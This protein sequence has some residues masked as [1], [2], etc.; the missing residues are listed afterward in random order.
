VTP[1]TCKAG[2][3][4]W[5]KAS[6]FPFPKGDT[7]NLGRHFLWTRDYEG[8]NDIS[9]FIKEHSGD[10]NSETFPEH[11]NYWFKVSPDAFCEA[12]KR[13]A[14]MFTYR[15]FDIS[16]IKLAMQAIDSEHKNKFYDEGVRIRQVG[17][18]E[19]NPKH[20]YSYLECGT[21][22]SLKVEVES[23][24]LNIR[25]EIAK[26]FEDGYVANRMKLVIVGKEPLDILKG[27]AIDLFATIPNKPRQPNHWET[28]APLGPDFLLTQCFV[29]PR[30]DWTWI[31]LEFPFLNKSSLPEPQAGRYICHLLDHQGPGS[32]CSTLDSEYWVEHVYS[33]VDVEI[34]KCRVFLT[35]EGFKHYQEVTKSVW[36]YLGLL[37]N[38]QPQEEIFKE[39]AAQ[40]DIA[41]KYQHKVPA[42]DFARRTSAA[43][44]KQLPRKHILN[45]SRKDS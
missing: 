36:Q 38:L 44:Q 31:D 7:T 41:F 43:M 22:N 37:T 40:T 23:R 12:L 1:I 13:F 39:I 14:Q 9:K 24:G 4:L 27:W 6:P 3:L 19:S 35:D 5:S 45:H 10:R 30:Q 17:K 8:G 16:S 25:D 21:F 34:L 26:A 11:T 18:C 29:K 15:E 2:P 33:F 20:P 28:E 32:I 42:S